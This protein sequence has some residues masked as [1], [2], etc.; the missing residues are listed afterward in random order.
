[1]NYAENGYRYD[2]KLTS[3]MV[4]DMLFDPILAA[5]VLLD[6]ELP[7]HEELRVLWMWGTHFT[8]DDSGFSTGKSYTHALVLAL[9]SILIPGRIS[10]VLSGTFRQG[11]LI[12]QYLE[13]WYSKSRIFRSCVKH[14]KGQPRFLHGSELWQAFFRGGSEVRVLPP[15][16]TTDS[17]RLRSERWNDGYIDEWVTFGNFHALTSTIFG[18]A[19][20]ANIFID[21][22]VRQNH[23]HL[24]STPGY[25]HDPAYALVKSIDRNIEAGSQD[26]GRFTVNYRHVPDTPKWRGLV[27]RKTIF[28]MQTMNPPGVV[29][30][31]I[32]GL[33]Q[34]DSQSYYSSQCIEAIRVAAIRPILRRYREQDIYVLG[35]DTARGQSPNKR[36]DGDDFSATVWRIP[37]GT[38]TPYPCHQVRK[39]NITAANMAGIIHELH[40]LFQFSWIL[41]D[42]L[43]GGMFV[44]DEMMKIEQIIRGQRKDVFPIVEFGSTSGVMGDP[45]LIPFKRS[46]FHIKQMWGT[47]GS[48]SVILNRLHQSVRH[49]IE[50]QSVAFPSQWDKWGDHESRC[51]LDSMRRYLTKNVAINDLERSRAELDLAIRQLILVDVVRDE[52][53]NPK[54]DSHGMYKFVSVFKKDAAY[55]LCYGYLAVMLFHYMENKGLSSRGGQRSSFAAYVGDV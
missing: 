55:S 3:M 44:R 13:R 16:I 14:Q 23:L 36:A 37:D 19:T 40:G 45:I 22:P 43:G 12:F 47:M 2:T 52:N 5:K 24:S 38:G 15:S 10:G 48:E 50:N 54:V 29:A 30:S 46:S 28:S 33:W 7:P 49:A 32:D 51:D 11:K 4:E 6:Q 20:A 18:R 53:N 34:S 27:D 21:C 17:L 25:T 41:Y 35:F 42:S 31:E 39:N 26:Y 8:M 1:V 9:R